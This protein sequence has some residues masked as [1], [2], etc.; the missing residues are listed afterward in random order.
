MMASLVY[1]LEA[2]PRS[3]G[4]PH[5]ASQWPDAEV[6]IAQLPALA[7]AP[8]IWV[9]YEIKDDEKIV[10]LWNTGLLAA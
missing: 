3:C 9:L 4:L 6:W 10:V 1:A 8:A 2:D 7:S 5:P